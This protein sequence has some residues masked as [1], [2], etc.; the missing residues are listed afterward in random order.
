[1]MLPTVS[2][3]HVGSQKLTQSSHKFWAMRHLTCSQPSSNGAKL[4]KGIWTGFELFSE[5]PHSS[6]PELH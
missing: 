6:E 3:Q 2:E 1:M 5:L 4:I